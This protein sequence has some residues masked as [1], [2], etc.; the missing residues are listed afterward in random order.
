[1]ENLNEIL[2]LV[3]L[4][5]LVEAVWET[6]KMV[7]D[8]N[9][10]SISAIGALVVGIVVSL[11]VNFDV[12]MVLKFDPVI[13]YVGVVLSG[14]LISRGGNFVH[15]WIKKISGGDKSNG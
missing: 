14:V 2:R 11:T 10:I 7:Y 15:E 6:L 9:K 3:V 13:P 8:K 12:L 1:M 4:A 5:F